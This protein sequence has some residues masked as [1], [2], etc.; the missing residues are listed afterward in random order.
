MKF[1]ESRRQIADAE[2]WVAGGVNSNFRMGIPPTPLVFESASG[3]YL[4]DVDGNRLVDYFLG[5]GPMLLG[6]SP[7]E[8]VRA[9]TDQLGRS[10][11]VGGQ[12]ELE[13]EAARLLLQLVPSAESVRFC[14]SGSEADQAALRLARAATGRSTVV[15]FEGHYHG[16]FDNVLWSV[17]PELDQMG[18]V[19][20]PVPVPGTAGQ[21]AAADIDVLPWNDAEAVVRRLERGDVAAVIMEPIMFNAA[22]ILP[23]QGYLETVRAACDATGTIL[24]F[25]EVI[26]GFRVAP[27]GAQEALGVLPDLTVLGKALASGFPVAALVGR[28][29]L[30]ELISNRTVLHG[31]TYNT[32]SVSMAATV[33]T[34]RTI[35]EGDVYATIAQTGSAL[36]SGLRTA[37]D[38]AGMEV[39]IVG[40]PAVFHVRFGA[41]G[42]RNY[43]EALAADRAGYGRFALALLE[44]GVRALP[45]GT[46][47][48]SREHSDADIELTL[49]AVRQA[50]TTA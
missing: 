43:R 25:D 14:S 24:I 37:F 39:S 28:A 40:Y 33:A 47:F 29:D 19:E 17:G 41:L 23:Q 31:G 4:V 11:L 49:D 38:D 2:S 7:A 27:G 21:V 48:L 22:G 18:P 16:W 26:T 12:T 6:H 10:I 34:L 3:P 44:R 9:A 5:M 15:K 8:V 36:M 1:T 46:W 32:Q 30:M 50:L 42:A 20:A 45:R 35:A 13:Y